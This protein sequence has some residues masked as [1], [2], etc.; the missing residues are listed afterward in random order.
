MKTKINLKQLLL[1]VVFCL[2]VL[3]GFGLDSLMI[4]RLSVQRAG[5]IYLIQEPNDSFSFFQI[6]NV[7][8]TDLIP[9]IKPFIRLGDKST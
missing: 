6:G 4:Q 5:D 9:I 7:D 8:S 2:T 1:L 3:K